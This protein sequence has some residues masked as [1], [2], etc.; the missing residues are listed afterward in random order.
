MKGSEKR[1]NV[2]ERAR[3]FNTSEQVVNSVCGAFK[4]PVQAPK[5]RLNKNQQKNREMKIEKCW[6]GWV[7]GTFGI[8]LKM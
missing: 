8:A 7:W 4:A 3:R 2:E 5:P 6:G 1:H